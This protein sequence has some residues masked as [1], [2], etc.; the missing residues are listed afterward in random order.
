[1]KNWQEMVSA[2]E[3]KHLSKMN[4]MRYSVVSSGWTAC[5]L[6]LGGCSGFVKPDPLP[7]IIFILADDLGYGD[8]SCLNPE[9]KI[10]TP[11]IDGIGERGVRFTDAHSSSAVCTPTRYSLLA[12]QYSWR[13]TLKKGVLNGYS[14]ALIPAGR[15][16]MAGMLKSRGYHTACIG[17]WHLGWDWHNVEKGADS[18]DFSRPVK[19]GPV[20]WGFDYFYGFSG[21]LDMPPYVYVENNMPTA[22]PDRRVKGN[23]A[24]VGSPD[25]TGAFWREGPTGSDFDF[26]ACLPNLTKRAVQYI[27]ERSSSGQPFFL[28][29]PLP[30]PHTPILPSGEFEGSSGINPYA[31]FVIMVDWVAGEIVKALERNGRL[32]NTLL[33]FTADNGCSPWADFQTL[34]KKGHWPG[35]IYR[36]HKADLYEGG[37]RI[38]CVVQWPER[39][40]TPGILSQT[41]C[42]N[43]FMRT[44]GELS[45]YTFK[46][47]E[48]EDSFSLL[49]VLT[50][51]NLKAVV[52]E[53][54]V[55]HSING[56]FAIRKGSWKLL[57][58]PGSG[59]W[60]FPRPGKESEGLPVM[61]LYHLGD[62]P[63]ETTN[64]FDSFPGVAEELNHELERIMD[65]GCERR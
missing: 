47:G 27:D 38:P 8:I 29:F 52:R 42:L 7:D 34:N 51:N 40:S 3:Y 6:L 28:Y 10:R 16:T 48:A 24:P 15:T 9:S 30:A 19:N 55:H 63:G 36:G 18:V 44:F 46:P 49:P 5:I 4:K 13:T 45:G 37:H 65:S 60:S 25:Y 62:D 11:H 59:G 41:I 50:G 53:T 26:E 43:D 20:D 33:V 17:K 23:N 58:S 35:F 1:M 12:G 54:V 32:Q 2:E 61:Q 57:K 21:S 56:D 39:I 64:L 14:P 22:L 31:D